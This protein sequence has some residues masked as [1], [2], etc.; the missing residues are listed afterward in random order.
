MKEDLTNFFVRL[1]LAITRILY[2][3]KYFNRGIVLD[4]EIKII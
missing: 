1:R 3:L 2:S 4:E